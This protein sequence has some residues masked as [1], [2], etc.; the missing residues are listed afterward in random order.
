MTWQVL[1]RRQTK[2]ISLLLRS[3]F[4]PFATNNRENLVSLCGSRTNVIVH[5][6]Y[7]GQVDTHNHAWIGLVTHNDVL[8]IAD[9]R[10]LLTQDV[11]NILSDKG[12]V[13]TV[14]VD[15]SDRPVLLLPAGGS[16]AMSRDQSERALPRPLYVSL[17]VVLLNACVACLS[18]TGATILL[19]A[20]ASSQ[21]VKVDVSMSNQT[22]E[23][24]G[25][26]LAWFANSVGSWT[27]TTNQNNL[28]NALFSP[29]SGL[30]LNYLRYNI[31]GGDDPL[32]GT[33][34]PHYACITPWY[35]AT[36]GYEPSSGTYSW[37]QDANQRWVATHAQSLGANLFEAVSYSPPYW[38]TNSGNV[39]R[40][41]KRRRQF[42][43]GILRLGLGDL[44]RLLDNRRPT[45]QQFIW[46]YLSPSGGSERTGTK[47]VD[48][49]RHKAGGVWVRLDEPGSDDSE[50]AKFTA[51][52]R[53]VNAGCR[54][55]RISGRNSQCESRNDRL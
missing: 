6:K 32:C 42:G 50:R 9:Y 7:T 33:G 15:N 51:S 54:N 45:F 21:T 53:L 55:G 29:T 22:L 48:R 43:F 34:S 47:L 4:F 14:Y 39:R 36:P 38:M 8:F 31:G 24:W 30:G 44:C 13:I 11:A 41:G 46:Y 28:M 19:S 5:V 10:S 1:T 49:G 37:T 23:G 25:T 12:R 18:N 26:S 20:P 17:L 3:G 16:P 27:N 52:K 35:H 40:W 2:Y